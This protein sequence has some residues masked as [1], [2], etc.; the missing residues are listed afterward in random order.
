MAHYLGWVIFF[1]IAWLTALALVPV[2]EWHRL[3]PSGFIGMAL[4]Y[5]IDTTFIGLGA[6]KYSF[7]NRALGGIPIFLAMEYITARLG[8]FHYLKW[9]PLK[10]FFLNIIGFTVVISLARWFGVI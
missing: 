4:I 2:E 7:D 10:S 1:I 5:I 3:W 6:F 9:N 8:Y